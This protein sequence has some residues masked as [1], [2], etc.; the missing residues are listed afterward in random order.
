MI[1]VNTTL[2]KRRKQVKEKKSNNNPENKSNSFVLRALGLILSSV[3]SGKLAI[4]NLS[5]LIKSV[6]CTLVTQSCQ[7]T[8]MASS[9]PSHH[10]AEGV[11]GELI[12]KLV[13]FASNG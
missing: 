7:T 8:D 4:C 5:A 11:R 12:N 1:E 9:H 10:S 3:L 13:R 2:L 6:I